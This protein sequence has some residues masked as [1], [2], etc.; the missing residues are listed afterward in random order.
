MRIRLNGEEYETESLTL[1]GLLGEL[2]IVHERVAVEVNL[3]IVKR[4]DR[5]HYRLREG[6]NIEIVNFVGGG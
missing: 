6:D 5:D 3:K 2:N 4:A 1:S